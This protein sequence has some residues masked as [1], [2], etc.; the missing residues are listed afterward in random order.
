[1]DDSAAVV[2]GAAIALAL[3]AVLAVGFVL[4][5]RDTIRKQGRWGINLRRVECPGCG[6]PAPVVRKPQNRRQMLWGGCTCP[7]CGLEYDKWG[8]AVRDAED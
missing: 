8:V 4:V 6:E 3:F 7:A 1:M 5:V 2:I